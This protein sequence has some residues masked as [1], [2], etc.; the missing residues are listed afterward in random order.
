MDT[1][2]PFLNIIIVED[3]DDL[4]ESIMD[5][6]SSLGH[7][8]QG[9][10]SVEALYEE[11]GMAQ[12]DLFIIDINLPGENGLSLADRLRASQPGVG[13]IM[14]TARTQSEERAEGYQCGADIYLTKPASLD[15]LCSAIRSLTRRLTTPVAV[16]GLVLDCRLLECRDTVSQKRVTL[17]CTEASLLSAFVRAPQQQLETFMVAEQLGL[18]LDNLNKASLEVQISRLRTKLARLAPETSPI[19][20]LRGWGYQLTLTLNLI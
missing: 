8:V 11:S 16:Q 17:T 12:V 10:D 9:V 2:D 5:A 14:L 1:R 4:R 6:L 18:D 20:A 19:K 7:H 3:N 15:E 13:I